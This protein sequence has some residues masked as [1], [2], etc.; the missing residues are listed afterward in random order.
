MGKDPA[1]QLCSDV[2][3]LGISAVL[4]PANDRQD[5]PAL[6]G[7]VAFGL[8]HLHGVLPGRIAGR[9][10]LCPFANII[11]QVPSSGRSA[12]RIA[13]AS[14][15]PAAVC[16]H[17]AS[18]SILVPGGETLT[19]WL[20]GLLLV[21]VGG[22][23]SSF[24]ATAPLLQKWFSLT[25]PSRRPGPVFPL[26]G[27]Q[28]RQLARPARLPTIRRA[29]V[30]TC[31]SE[32]VLGRG[33]RLPCGPGLDLRGDGL[34]V[35][36]RG[37]FGRGRRPRRDRAGA[38]RGRPPASVDRAGVRAVESDAGSDDLHRHRPGF[39]T[40]PVESFRWPSTS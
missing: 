13:A 18:G 27:Q 5:D 4:R 19:G 11:D 33:L 31:T 32:Q 12:C 26:R 15:P 29:E 30:A 14:T 7:R 37:G 23:S 21:S 3:P 25:V 22:R 2:I 28:L 20:L 10:L 9:L 1:L 36:R 16:H 6:A 38:T 24:S 40:T 8:E 34:A 39:C 17:A 35:P